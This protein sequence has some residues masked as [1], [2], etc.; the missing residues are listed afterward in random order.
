MVGM[1]V[2][3]HEHSEV[4]SGECLPAHLTRTSAELLGRKALPRVLDRQVIYVLGPRGVG[5][6]QVAR[7]LAGADALVL[8]GPGLRSAVAI[9]ARHG[10]FPATVRDAPALV[11]DGVDCLYARYGFVELV[12][13]LL[14][15]RAEAGR[16]TILVQGA[17]DGSLT[18][19]FA[20]VPNEL[21]ASVL[22]RFPVGS[23][24]KKHV[25]RRCKER[26]LPFARVR[27][28]VQ[29]DPWTYERVEQ[30]LDAAA[31]P[32]SK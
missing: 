21:R 5:K 30:A 24:R 8:D 2:A 11:I 23:G 1:R 15:E 9:R 7:R 19:L 20:P 31:I 14:R 27:H 12:G 10:A 17:A 26:G 28:V 6:S 13:G 18:L 4:A 22:L 25:L 16:R 29:L 32:E 3:D